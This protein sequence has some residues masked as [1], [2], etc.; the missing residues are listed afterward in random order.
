MKTSVFIDGFNFYYGC[1]K[2]QTAFQHCKWVDLRQLAQQILP[3][4][5]IHRV[6]YFSAMVAATPWDPDQ[7]L[8]QETYFRALRTL[9]KLKIHLGKFQPVVRKGLPHNPPPGSSPYPVKIQTWEEKGSDVNLATTLLMD[10]FDGD[11][12]QALVI[13]NDSD[14]FE[15]IRLVKQRF[16]LPIIVVS[17]HASVTI[18]LQRASSTWNV[19]D[20]SLLAASQLPDPV[21]DKHGKI[22]TKPLSW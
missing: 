16:N 20:K 22:I 13:S 18:K 17:P 11:F 19:L 15:P 12:E 3:N 1:F 7:P 14:L 8:R 6:H 5:H 9:P 2:N 4:D 10:A 21:V